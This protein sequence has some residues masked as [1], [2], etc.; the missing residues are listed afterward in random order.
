MN[1]DSP[2]L[3]LVPAFEGAISA[4]DPEELDACLHG[5]RL[6]AL[7]RDALRLIKVSE[8]AIT[9]KH[10]IQLA[11]YYEQLIGA[12]RELAGVPLPDFTS[13]E[14]SVDRLTARYIKGDLVG[15][16]RA[17]GELTGTAAYEAPDIS[18]PNYWACRR[19]AVLQDTSRGLDM[20][21]K[22]LLSDRMKAK[23]YEANLHKKRD[24]A[25]EELVEA[26][27]VAP[28]FKEAE[29]HHLEAGLMRLAREKLA[30]EAIV[31]GRVSRATSE[32]DALARRETFEVLPGGRSLR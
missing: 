29:R 25:V 1:K 4:I 21:V 13:I 8:A 12:R 24:L 31:E 5:V 27:S 22:D 20:F 9:S 17:F 32:A 2:R 11:P 6:P 30:R 16:G 15:V 14:E 23:L 10:K 28:A 7:L 26:T 19:L 18:K 3:R